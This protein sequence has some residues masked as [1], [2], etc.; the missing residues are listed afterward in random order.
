MCQVIITEDSTFDQDFCSTVSQTSESSKLTNLFSHLSHLSP[1][2]YVPLVF[3]TVKLQASSVVVVVVVVVVLY[4]L[5]CVPLKYCGAL[6][7]H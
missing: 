6:F 1:L 5:M 7:I 3:Q 2:T 4:G